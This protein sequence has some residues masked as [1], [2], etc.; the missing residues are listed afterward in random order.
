MNLVFANVDKSPDASLAQANSRVNASLGVTYQTQPS[1]FVYGH[2]KIQ[3]TF[4]RPA[5]TMMS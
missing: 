1:D 4:S 3:I 5:G 2:L